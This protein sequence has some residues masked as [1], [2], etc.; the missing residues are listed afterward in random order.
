M[1]R[2]KSGLPKYCHWTRD[3]GDGNKRRVRFRNKKTGFGVYLYGT[4]WSEDFMKAYAA[5]LD[6]STARRDR[7]TGQAHHRWHRQRADRELL[8]GV[9]L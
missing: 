6:G 8:H 7:G 3:H 1:L 2:T 9:E 4:P 5:A